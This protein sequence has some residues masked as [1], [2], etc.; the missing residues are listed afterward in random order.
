MLL[1]S[2]VFAAQYPDPISINCVT[3]VDS[4]TAAWGLEGQTVSVT[5]SVTCNIKT[6]KE[7]LTS[8][9]GGMPGNKQ[10]LKALTG[11]SFFKDNQTLASLNLGGG[12]TIELV[13]KTRGGGKK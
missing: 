8:V 6:L 4:S 2:A 11:G 10:Q 5:V 7:M 1:S 13:C 3:P 12:S 9:L